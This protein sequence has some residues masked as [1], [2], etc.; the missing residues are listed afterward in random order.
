MARP[1]SSSTFESL[2]VLLTAAYDCDTEWQSEARCSPERYERTAGI[3][4]PWQFNPE[5]EVEVDR[6][7]GTLVVLKGTEMIELGLMSCFACPAQYDC[8]RYAMCA[9]MRAGTWGMKI[10]DLVWLQRKK[11]PAKTL[12]DYAEAEAIPLQR[13]IPLARVAIDAKQSC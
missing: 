2:G 3:P 10:G 11:T 7:D 6:G 4:S 5:Q 13:A 1:S 12:I 8:A 9:K